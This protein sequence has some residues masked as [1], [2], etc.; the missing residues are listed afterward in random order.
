MPHNYAQLEADVAAVENYMDHQQHTLQK[1][2]ALNAI[3]DLQSRLS[4]FRFAMHTTQHS[5]HI[6]TSHQ[7]R[8]KKCNLQG[9]RQGGQH[10]GGGLNYGR[11]SHQA[12]EH[13]CN[14][15]MFHSR[16]GGQQACKAGVDVQNST[17][18]TCNTRRRCAQP[19]FFFCCES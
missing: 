17:S 13:D 2:V 9:L 15:K 1:Q 4:D 5:H 19:P 3:D 11:T 10:C 12:Q 6:N 18:G 16:L 14:R 7:D 8:V